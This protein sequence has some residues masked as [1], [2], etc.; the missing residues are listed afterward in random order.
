MS[1]GAAPRLAL[2]AHD[3][4]KAR[5]V[6][7]AA[8]HRRALA[9]CR[10]HATGTTGARIAAECP[11]LRIHR[12]LSGP[13]GGDLQ[14]GAWIAEKRIDALVFFVDA[15]S[16]MPHD[17][18]VKALMRVAVLCEVPLALNEATA[19]CLLASLETFQPNGDDE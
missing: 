16:A 17:V 18:D 6:Q 14:V 13:L 5:M 15:L 11:E 9:R 1:A 3:A 12:F 7:W 4:C 10:L 19:E 2:I 8:R